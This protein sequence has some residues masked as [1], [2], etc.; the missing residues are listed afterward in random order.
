MWLSLKQNTQLFQKYVNMQAH[1]DHETLHLIFLNLVMSIKRV[2][3]KTFQGVLHL[4]ILCLE[5]SS[6]S[7]DDINESEV[8]VPTNNR[9]KTRCP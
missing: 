4:M 3:L 6:G 7:S 5:D 1:I 2:K 8:E 9:H